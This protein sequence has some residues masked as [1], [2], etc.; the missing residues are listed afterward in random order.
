MNLINDILMVYYQIDSVYVELCKLECMGNR[1][2]VDFLELVK[3]LKGLIEQEK[4]LF[5]RFYNEFEDARSYKVLDNGN[6]F[7]K[8]MID[9]MDFN[10]LLNMEIVNNKTEEEL[11]NIK[12]ARLYGTC[13]K[14]VF[15]MYLSFLQ[16]YIDDNNYRNIK[17]K[18]LS[19]KYYNAFINHDVEKCLI[20]FNFKISKVNY[21]D[22]YL[23]AGLLRIDS[24]E[25]DSIIL[26]CL[27]DTLE[28]T[29][30]QI[31]SI[32]DIDYN[33][34]DKCAISLNNQAMLRSGLTIINNS[35]F[36]KNRDWLFMIIDS[37]SNKDNKI[38]SEIVKSIIGNMNRDKCRVRKISLNPID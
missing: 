34:M 10:Q 22:L 17:N 20:D 11:F 3:I 15:L 18:L 35:D 37:L 32:K 5:N 21:M 2:S 6:L 23:V 1:D 16:E 30:R 28:V 4:R 7:T 33:E 25:C 36:D 26:D 29:I 12:C 8:R 19:F 24:N 38:S 9:Y 14:N 27:K 13:S 31:L